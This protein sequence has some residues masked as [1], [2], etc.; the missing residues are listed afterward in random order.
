M[1]NLRAI[2]FDLDDTLLDDQ[3]SYVR[4]LEDAC[5]FAWRSCH[6]RGW[7]PLFDAYCRVSDAMWRRFDEWG[8]ELDG[9]EI[10]LR[11]WQQ[12]FA[13]MRSPVDIEQVR[14]VAVFYAR[15]RSETHDWLAGAREALMELGRGYRVGLITNGAAD[16]QREKLRR[17]AL[18]AFVDPVLIGGE[19]GIAKPDRRIFA[20]ALAAADVGPHEAL[21]V[22]DKA[23]IDIAGAHAAGMHAVWIAPAGLPWP[24]RRREP[25][26][27]LTSVAE[28]PNAL[29]MIAGVMEG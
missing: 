29:R 20:Q 8:R 1:K 9:E 5:R 22:G 14:Q 27:R 3:G 21:M 19:V 2:F 6:L 7:K 24:L 10:R 28:L 15:R 25:V 16:I 23:E 17:M 4:A 26:M 13:A 11:V 12:T 18:P